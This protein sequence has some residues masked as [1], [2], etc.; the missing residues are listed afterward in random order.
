MLES[1]IRG[2]K[3]TPLEVL[4]AETMMPPIQEYLDLLE[5]KTRTRLRTG[6]QAAF[7]KN[8]CEKVAT[9]LE[10]RRTP[11]VV[12][13]PGRRKDQWALSVTTGLQ[14]HRPLSDPLP[15]GQKKRKMR[16][17]KND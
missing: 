2:D 13:T 10:K 6:R 17:M 9:K 12:D 14:I 4:H 16:N 8:Q 7:I 15:N 11:P 1:S 3:A 5:A